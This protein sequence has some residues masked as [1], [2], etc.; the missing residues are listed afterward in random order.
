MTFMKRR[1]VAFDFENGW[2]GEKLVN[3]QDSSDSVEIYEFPNF[4]ILF[5]NFIWVF[6]ILI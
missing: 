6:V 2:E 1:T 4:F 3:F 5:K